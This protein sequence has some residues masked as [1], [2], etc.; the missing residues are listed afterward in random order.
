[1]SGEY[2]P[3]VGEPREMMYCT[4]C[5]EAYERIECGECGELLEGHCWCDGTG[6]HLC[7]KCMKKLE[8]PEP[9]KK[10]G[11]MKR[12]ENEGS[13]SSQKPKAA[14]ETPKEKVVPAR[15]R[16]YP[17]GATYQTHWARKA[18]TKHLVKA[19]YTLAELR[20]K[21]PTVPEETIQEALDEDEGKWRKMSEEAEDT[22]PEEP[23]RVSVSLNSI[24]LPKYAKILGDSLEDHVANS[25][26]GM[27]KPI[28]EMA[29]E[30][31]EEI[32]DME[33]ASDLLESGQ[34]LKDVKIMLKK[35][36]Y[37]E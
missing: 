26:D 8:Q 30:I 13:V 17:G 28:D 24:D 19:G 36:R 1:M 14:D 10:P 21:M 23:V 3:A 27:D 16:E 35:L 11:K 4:N 22:N 29:Q 7:M 34:A 32:M 33:D 5:E 6:E 9:K 15:D 2:V 20:E 12:K 18:K 37:G 25:S 31:S